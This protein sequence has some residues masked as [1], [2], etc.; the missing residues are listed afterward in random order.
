M[1]FVIGIRIHDK[2]LWYSGFKSE[3]TGIAVSVITGFIFGL[4]T[5]WSETKWGSSESFPTDEMR[6]R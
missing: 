1:G 6:I 3:C 2:E 5:T 4:C